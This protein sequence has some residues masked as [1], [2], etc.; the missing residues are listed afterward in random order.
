MEFDFGPGFISIEEEKTNALVSF[1]HNAQDV[2]DGWGAEETSQGWEDSF[3]NENNESII[4]LEDTGLSPLALDA[5]LSENFLNSIPASEVWMAPD[6]S[7]HWDELT[8]PTVP[9][10]TMPLCI[11]G[12]STAT[13][14]HIEII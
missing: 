7:I 13:G 1:Y 9:T 2:N 12:A 4:C 3:E 10:S 11:F 14:P 5:S 6:Y 8:F